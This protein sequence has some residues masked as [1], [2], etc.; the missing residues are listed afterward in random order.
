MLFNMQGAH[1]FQHTS[2]ETFIRM[3]IGG[4][5]IVVQIKKKIR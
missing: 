5:R 1:A 2:C 3:K 4:T